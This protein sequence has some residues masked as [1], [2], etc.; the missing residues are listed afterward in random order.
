[1][2][3]NEKETMDSNKKVLRKLIKISEEC[4]FHQKLPK[5]L[6]DYIIHELD[7]YGPWPYGYSED[8]LFSRIRGMAA[9]FFEGTLDITMKEPVLLAEEHIGYLRDLYGGAMREQERLESRIRKLE[10][11]LRNN[12][13][14]IV[15]IYDEGI[16]GYVDKYYRSDDPEYQKFICHSIA[17]TDQDELPFS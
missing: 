1:M 12:G 3:I 16:N 4:I 6:R 17:C 7:G 8:E 15:Y 2:K 9:S 14:N 11:E 5:K 10:N 13:I